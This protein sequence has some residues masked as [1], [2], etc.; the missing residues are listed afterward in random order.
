MGSRW[1]VPWFIP[2]LVLAAAIALVALTGEEGRSASGA[3]PAAGSSPVRRTL[4]GRTTQHEP[5]TAVVSGGRLVAFDA[6][7][8]LRCLGGDVAST[9][10]RLRWQAD[11]PSRGSDGLATFDHGL[12][13][14]QT[15]WRPALGPGRTL[16]DRGRVAPRND[17][18]R[19]GNAATSTITAEVAGDTL[20]G[21]LL[22][23]IAVKTADGSYATCTAGGVR[24]R[25]ER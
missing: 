22:T 2:P 7:L 5:I 23:S 21:T 6:Q 13:A 15:T 10:R 18:P 24:F 9:P 1:A 8:R 25:L 3:E 11:V 20:T 19:A 4:A 12:I 14:W 17:R 16:V